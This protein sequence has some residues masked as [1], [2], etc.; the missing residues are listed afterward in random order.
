MNNQKL[1]S[2]IKNNKLLKAIQLVEELGFFK[3][4]LRLNA[5]FN[6][7]EKL[8]TNGLIT[9]EIYDVELNKVRE[10]LLSYVTPDSELIQ[11]DLNLNLSNIFLEQSFHLVA[12]SFFNEKIQRKGTQLIFSCSPQDVI[13]VE[14]QI[15]ELLYPEE[16]LNIWSWIIF[17]LST[18]LSITSLITT[19]FK[20]LIIPPILI[21]CLGIA[22]MASYYYRKN[23]RDEL[24]R[25]ISYMKNINTVIDFK[26]GMISLSTL[27]KE[28]RYIHI[29]QLN[30]ELVKVYRPNH[31]YVDISK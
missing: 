4:S 12:K 7:I 2:L 17:T 26:S 11:D 20:L 27:K 28:H 13:T 6:K 10:S 31:G 16:G 14:T 23:Q 3:D 9:Q 15:K 8:R 18:I 30:P 5:K 1:S 24:E 29:T 25:D 21:M 19:N 22:Y